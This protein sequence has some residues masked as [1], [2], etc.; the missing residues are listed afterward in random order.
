MPLSVDTLVRLDVPRE[1]ARE[2]LPHLT[3]AM[4][5]FGITTQRRAECFLAQLWHES[6]ALHFFEEIASGAAYE[7]R[8][9]LGNTHPGD[10]VRY[11]GRGPIQLT[12][13]GNYRKAGAA[14][15]VD[16]EAH[17]TLVATPRYGYLVAAWYWNGR[18]LNALA[19]QDRFEEITRRI[20]GA[21]TSGP[22]SHHARRVA[23][24]K[25]FQQHDVRPGEAVLAR[26]AEG[27][28]VVALTRRLSYVR[29]ARTG[30]PYLDGKRRRFDLETERAL[31]RFQR[32]HHLDVDGVYGST[33]VKALSR[34]VAL[35][36]KQRELEKATPP[37]DTPTPMQKPAHNER[38]RRSSAELIARLDRV[39]A[40]RDHALE[41]LLRRGI[42]LERLVAKR[43]ATPD[44]A[45]LREL[46]DELGRLHPMIGEVRDTLAR[47]TDGQASEIAEAPPV[48]PG[49]CEVEKAEPVAAPDAETNGGA[50]AE[51]EPVAAP[52]AE[53]NGGAP[54]A[55][56]PV[57]EPDAE[58]NG[59]APS[60]PAMAAGDGPATVTEIAARLRE[61][62]AYSDEMRAMLAE[63][64]LLLEA[65]AHELAP[66]RDDGRE[67][68]EHP[69]RRRHHNRG[70]RPAPDAQLVLGE[71]ATPGA[72]ATPEPARGPTFRLTTPLLKSPRVTA[73]QRL[74]NRRFAEWKVGLRIELDGEYGPETKEAVRQ[75]MFGM[76]ISTK[77]LEGGVTPELRERIRHPER[78]T[79]AE[80]ARARKRREWI[81]RLRRRHDGHGPAAA[82]AYAREHLGV[83]EDAGRPNRGKLIDK[84]NTATGIPHGPNAFWCGAFVNA[85]LI[86]AGFPPDRVLAY[87][88]SIEDRAQAGREGWSWHSTPRPGDLALFTHRYP[89]GRVDAGHVGIVE[90]VEGNAVITIEG[91]TSPN[92]TSNNGIGVF[93]RR[94]MLP[95]RG[96]ARPPYKH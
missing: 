86:A 82:I 33:T 37:A 22:P 91:N 52:D 2:H 55:A 26:G 20:N 31:K 23:W 11:K 7:G 9:D 96:F 92:T 70:E 57:A 89:D 81:R 78:R 13:R 87:C 35:R 32:E 3:A 75:V 74:L 8:K 53:T 59:G 24:R 94:R 10:G 15:K 51:A 64:V 80:R 27:A 62:G 6:A 28:A 65:R 54:A 60:E 36:K 40:R 83:R 45:S 21:A 93:R 84:W 90:R 73:F 69:K 4:R 30:N 50:P 77:E 42:R 46:A 19:D 34:A 12:G 71:H 47:A 63:Q 49:A 66:R 44:L 76:G 67:R 56:E 88:P 1:K 58:T 38:A 61:N 79:A 48:P 72:R 14:L 41:F 95:I 17:P 25:R 16:F 5:K 39:D 68:R 85:C 18:G 29:S 43:A